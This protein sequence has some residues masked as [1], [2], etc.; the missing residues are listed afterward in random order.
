MVLARTSRL[1]VLRI[2]FSFIA[3]K[4][5]D[6]IS[7][8]RTLSRSQV[9]P[10]VIAAFFALAMSICIL[11]LVAWKTMDAKA[12]KLEHGQ[13]AVQN[14]THSLAEQASH[15]ILAVDIA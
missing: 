4:M 1:C 14:L 11:G 8:T 6:Y 5:S 3:R 10:V 9:A 2:C 13:T 12:I 7:A 15:T